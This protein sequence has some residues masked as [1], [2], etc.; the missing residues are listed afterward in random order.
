MGKADGKI[1]STQSKLNPILVS[2]LTAQNKAI[3]PTSN[4]IYAGKDY[5]NNILSPNKVV[6]TQTDS[7]GDVTVYWPDLKPKS[8]Y[9]VFVTAAAS[10]LLYEPPLLWT[11][12]A[13]ITFNFTTLPNPNIGGKANQEASLK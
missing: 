7:N 2:T 10:P 1:T 6:K 4:Q 12:D 13:V 5:Q 3:A 9:I 8:F 11:D